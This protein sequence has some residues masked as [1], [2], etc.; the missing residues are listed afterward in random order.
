MGLEHP[1]FQAHYLELATPHV[2]NHPGSCH[3]LP[4]A[5]PWAPQPLVGTEEAGRAPSLTCSRRL[6]TPGHTAVHLGAYWVGVG[7]PGGGAGVPAVI[8]P[9]AL[10]VHSVLG[11]LWLAFFT[12]LFTICC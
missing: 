12:L 1:L 4:L 2:Q 5:A 6:P 10:L 11:S 7:F 3:I 9:F 8:P